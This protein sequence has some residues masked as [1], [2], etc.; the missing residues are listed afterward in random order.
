MPADCAAVKAAALAQAGQ[1]I[2]VERNGRFKALG[3]V[4]A[5]NFDFTAEIP[6]QEHDANPYGVLPA[7]N[8]AALV[9]D[10]GSNT[11]NLVTDDGLVSVLH[12]FHL[13]PP[14]GVFPSDAVPTCVVRAGG[15]LWVADLS[16]RLFRLE[17]GS[18]T[19]ISVVDSGGK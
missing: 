15:K 3:S 2:S 8:G 10:A 9:A 11:L 5:F 6:N 16:G 1:L 19:Q 7:G 13:E 4:G 12:Y 14:A 18:A 17:G